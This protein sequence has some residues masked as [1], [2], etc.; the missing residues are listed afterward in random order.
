MAEP[1]ASIVTAVY[2]AVPHLEFFDMQKLLIHNWPA[3]AWP[4]VTGASL[5]AAGYTAFFLLA[6]CLV[7]QRKALN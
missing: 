7:F 1:A 3:I 4:Y 2:F 5:Y 6:T